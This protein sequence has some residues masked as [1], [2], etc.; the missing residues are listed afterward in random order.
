[1]KINKK[2][3]LTASSSVMTPIIKIVGNSCNLH[4][5]YCFYHTQNQ[6]VFK[7]MEEELLEKF[8]AEYLE[9][10][11]GRVRFIWHG[12]EP[13]LAGIS[14]F[15]KITE[16]QKRYQH[17]NQVIRNSVQTNATLITDEWASF[18]KE[19]KFDIGVSLD[20]DKESHDRFRKNHHGRGSFDSAI[21]GVEILEKH[22][23]QPGFIQV[24]TKNSQKRV[25]ED[26]NF[27]ANFLRARSWG[28]NP[29]LDLDNLNKCMVG[30]NITN[31]EFAAYLKLYIDY[32]LSRDDPNLRIREI[33]NFFSGVQG[34]LARTCSFNGN[35]TSFFCLEW[36]GKIY[37]CD[38]FSGKD[39]MLFG[40]LSKDSLIKILNGS[41]RLRYAWQVNTIHP[42]CVNCEWWQACHNGCSHHRIGGI[43]GQY[44]YCK[45]RKTIFAYLKAKI[46]EYKEEVMKNDRRKGF[47]GGFK[48][49][50]T[51]SFK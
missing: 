46:V 2:V 15:Q 47:R 34:R 29:Y 11:R 44:Y 27:F 28:I 35:C 43:T 20:G 21:K 38:R 19:Y 9:L 12:G 42:N 50:R 33:D 6:K 41:R 39:E 5:D 17:N 8:I 22:D 49:G 26:F 7:V 30:F 51:R 37:P 36:D 45:A 23:I 3:I 40:D 32:W 24:V 13:L 14:F 1:M 48:A 16:Y 4:C 31:E 25:R 10:F 18:L